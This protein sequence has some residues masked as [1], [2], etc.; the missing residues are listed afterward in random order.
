MS[1]DFQS[2]ENSSLLIKFRLFSMILITIK[3]YCVKMYRLF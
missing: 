3:N 2:V 1:N